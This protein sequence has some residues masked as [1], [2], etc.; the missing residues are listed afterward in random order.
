ML[1]KKPKIIT[2]VD[3]TIYIYF[4]FIFKKSLRKQKKIS[5]LGK[6]ADTDLKASVADGLSDREMTE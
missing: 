1:N 2:L 6:P 5:R 3:K 4:F